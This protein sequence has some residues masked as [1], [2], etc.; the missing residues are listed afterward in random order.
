M[1]NRHLKTFSELLGGYTLGE[2]EKCPRCEEDGDFNNKVE[3][4]ETLGEIWCDS[5]FESYLD[6][7]ADIPENEKVCGHDLW[8]SANEDN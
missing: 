2:K 1:Q 7:Q 8:L 4:F 6:N 5:C 3:C